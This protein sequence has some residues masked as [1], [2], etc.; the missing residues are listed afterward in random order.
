[1]ARRSMSTAGRLEAD[2]PFTPAPPAERLTVSE[3]AR[4]IPVHAATDVLVARDLDNVLAPG[5]HMSCDP[6]TQAFMREIPQ[7]WM[8]GQA[9]GVAEALAVAVRT[10]RWDR[11]SPPGG[12]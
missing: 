6:Q 7:C 11:E 1:M 5:R 10:D 8:T 12:A 2:E 4:E 9:A 3:P